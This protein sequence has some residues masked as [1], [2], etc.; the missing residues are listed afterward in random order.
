M[1]VVC[2]LIQ[3][4]LEKGRLTDVVVVLLCFVSPFSALTLSVG[5]QEGYLVCKS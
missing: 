5:Q 1:V 4:V 2:R 3:V